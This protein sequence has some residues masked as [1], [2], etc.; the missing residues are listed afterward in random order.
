MYAAHIDGWIES[1]AKKQVEKLK[2][3]FGIKRS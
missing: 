2:S 1:A 3:D